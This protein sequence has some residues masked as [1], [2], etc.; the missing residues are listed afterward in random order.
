MLVKVLPDILLHE[1]NGE[2]NFLGVR[3]P[4]YLVCVITGLILGLHPA[5]E[6]CRYKVTQSLIGWVQT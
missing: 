6:R 1:W 4:E 3:Y 2:W 5:Y